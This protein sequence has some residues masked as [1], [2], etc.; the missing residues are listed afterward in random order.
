MH[1]QQAYA[2]MQKRY[3][4]NDAPLMDQAGNHRR[5]DTNPDYRGILLNALDRKT[6]KFKGTIA[7]DFGCGQGRNV[8]NMIMWW[9]DLFSRVDG[10][11]I[12]ANNIS[13]CE[14]NLLREVGD[15]SKWKF[16]VNNGI[17]LCDLESNKYSFVMSTIVLQ[18]IC[19]H[20]TRFNLMKEIYRVMKEGGTFSF[21]MGF[22]EGHPNTSSYYDNTYNARGTNSAHD[23][24]VIDP[25]NLESDL[26][27]IGFSDIQ[28]KI[29][30]PDFDAHEKWI[31]VEAVK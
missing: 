18:H 16:F 4:E 26:K 25:K 17:D 11:D 1:N 20:E 12:S 19:V 22:G 24:K 21:Q 30:N 15:S 8:S 14:R 29:S 3:Y 23:V 31:F 27:E 28:W 5:H 7:L 10:V 2:D 13:Y 6:E 9:P